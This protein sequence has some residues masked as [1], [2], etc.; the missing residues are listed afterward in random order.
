MTKEQRESLSHELAVMIWN[1]FIARPH[2]AGKDYDFSF[3][4]LESEIGRIIS[5]STVKNKILTRFDST[6]KE[7]DDDSDK[8]V[9]EIKSGII[10]CGHCGKLK[11]AGVECWSE[12][13]KKCTL[14]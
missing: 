10:T 12:I 13:N 6:F 7:L 5:D 11:L 4:K 3:T 1:D 2:N 9:V 8:P 14:L